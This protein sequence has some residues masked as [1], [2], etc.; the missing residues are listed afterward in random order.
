MESQYLAQYN[1]I[2]LAWM[3]KLP[4]KKVQWSVKE[5]QHKK[6]NTNRYNVG[7]PTGSD[8]NLFVVDVDKKDEGLEEWQQYVDKYGEPN[9]FKV[10]SPNGGYH[11]YFQY[12]SNN[13]Q[14][15]EVV[16][17]FRNRSKQRNDKGIDIRT[18]TGYIVAPPS[19]T[20]NGSYTVVNDVEVSPI[21]VELV[22][23][24]LEGTKTTKPKTETNNKQTNQHQ[25]QQQYTYEID[26]EQ[27]K[28]L[29]NKL[30]NN[31]VDVYSDWL[32]ITTI[33]KNMDKREIWE[34]WSKQ[35]Q[36]YDETG[37]NRVWAWEGFASMDVNYI[38]SVLKL[39]RIHKFKQQKPITI[40]T[41]KIKKLVMDNK[42]VFD[43]TYEGKQFKYK[44]F[45]D[46]QTI[47]LKSDTGT[48][49]T[50]AVAKH[51]KKYVEKHGMKFLSIT[52]RELMS[53]QHV[54]SFEDMDM[55]L[56]QNTSNAYD[57]DCFTCCV[58]S[59][60]SRLDELS[61]EELNDYVVYFDE[62]TSFLQNFTHNKTLE[63]QMRDVYKFLIR[64][65]KNAGKVIVSDKDITDAVFM[66]LKHRPDETKIFITNKFQKYKGIKAIRMRNEDEFMDKMIDKVN[67]NQCFLFGCDSKTTTEIIHSLCKDHGC[68]PDNFLLITADSNFDLTDANVQF[69][70]KFVFYS[71]KLTYGVDF[72]NIDKAQ[73][74]FIYIKG[75]TITPFMAYQQT[76]RCRNIKRLYYF[77]ETESKE[78]R[79][80]SIEDT[81][82]TYKQC[83][84]TNMNITN[85]CKTINEKDEDV[86]VENLFFELFCYNEYMKD[87]YQTN[88]R[89][90]FEQILRDEGFQLSEVGKP[91]AMDKDTRQQAKDMVE[92]MNEQLL[93]E[94]L[95]SFDKYGNNS[96][97][98]R[99]EHLKRNIKALGLHKSDVETIRKYKDMVLDSF[100]VEQHFHIMATMRTDAYIDSKLETKRQETYDVCLLH[101][102]Y[103]KV[104]LLRLFEKRFGIDP[105]D[106]VNNR[107]KNDPVEMT[108]KEH[109]L[110]TT[111]FRSSKKK[112]TNRAEIMKMYVGMLKNIIGHD[113][114]ESTQSR[115]KA[116]RG[117]YKYVL[118]KH[119]VKTSL[120]LWQT[121]YKEFKH[122]KQECLDVFIPPD[123]QQQQQEQQQ[124]QEEPTDADFIDTEA[125]HAEPAEENIF[126]TE[127]AQPTN[128]KEKQF[129]PLDDIVFDSTTFD[130]DNEVS[131]TEKT[132]TEQT[133]TVS[134]ISRQWHQCCKCKRWS[135]CSQND[136]MYV[137]CDASSCS[138]KCSELKSTT[139]TQQATKTKTKQNKTDTCSCDYP[140]C[141]CENPRYE[142]V[143]SN[144]QLYCSY[145]DKWKC[146]CE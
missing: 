115:K 5:N 63:N 141:S 10:S 124:P 136:G 69:K 17:H 11:Y 2:K 72:N 79:Y 19:K 6:I 74:V 35:S 41:N 70:D 80:E 105:F 33:L 93:N 102:D 26:D 96:S 84:K 108:D 32:I 36:K 146:R 71:P 30:P 121:V 67:K 55:K 140:T 129:D 54:S 89:M 97:D 68:D 12:K 137:C 103:N 50:T 16:S 60:V 77:S 59:L 142:L 51:A 119:M 29:L 22:S 8:N 117:E 118:N 90:H 114:I 85:I 7:I 28:Q 81:K 143:K 99:F 45:K 48:G 104:K 127:E 42:H 128:T 44:H 83:I 110:Y 125:E 14:L 92:E 25:H 49:K 3:R 57:V 112:P 9:T 113:V 95:D 131:E 78:A 86:L 64:I 126:I 75:H 61:D 4:I 34:E 134:P 15:D 27:L 91:K 120:E 111:L 98:S 116:D 23:W 132:T 65:V 18:N 94:Y 100:R 58:N 20:A 87:V 88:K 40:K 133:Q 31:F 46:Y 24:L 66:F 38:T 53:K 106:V 107:S 139:Q 37:N 73:D 56:Y 43:E 62:I 109:K 135:L 138:Q 13:Q 39:P 130:S 76:T 101:T 82:Q 122:M 47:I 1:K 145:C 144:N 123:E 52:D 21:P